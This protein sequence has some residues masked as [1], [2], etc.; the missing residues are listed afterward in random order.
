M[1][2]T[3]SERL[4]AAPPAVQIETAPSEGYLRAAVGSEPM[5]LVVDDDANWNSLITAA[6]KGL[7]FTSFAVTSGDEA[8]QASRTTRFD[9]G[10]LDLGLPGMS[11]LET[12]AALKRHDPSMTIVVASGDGSIELA[13][14][15][16]RLGAYDFL[17]KTSHPSDIVAALRR[18]GEERRVRGTA[19]LHEVSASLM[20]V[21]DHV[22]LLPRALEIAKRSLGADG[23]AIVRGRA[24]GAEP[25]RID[26]DQPLSDAVLKQCHSKVTEDRKSIRLSTLPRPQSEKPVAGAALVC[27][28]VGRG[29]A[30]AS[31][32]LVRNAGAPAFSAAELAD[33][34]VL[35]A[36]LAM[37]LENAELFER[38]QAAEQEARSSEARIRAVVDACPDAV[39]TIDRR[40]VIRDWNPAAETMYRYPAARAV[41]SDYRELIVPEAH[42]SGMADDVDRDGPSAQIAVLAAKNALCL[43]GS[44]EE[45]PAAVSVTPI[46]SHGEPLSCIFVRDL[47]AQTRL[48]VELRHAQK[49]ESVGRL[50]AGV[51]HEINTPIQFIGDS[52]E[53]ARS[54]FEALRK[55]VD[56]YRQHAKS[57]S[58][59]ALMAAEEEADL[60]YLLEQLP[61]AIGRTLDGVS[62]VARI[63]RAMKYFAHPG[64][65]EKS[66]ADLNRAVEETLIVASNE[67]KY[68]AAVELELGDIPQVTCHLEDVNQVLLNLVVN[69][70][71]AIESAN[72]HTGGRGVIRIRTRHEAPSVV[73]EISDT[74]CGIP[75]SIK[76]KVFDAFFTTKEPGRG[77]GQGLAL[78]RAVIVDKHGG[79]LTFESVEGAGTTFFIRLP[80]G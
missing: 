17:E 27:P 18:A 79:T 31:L 7:G 3:A 66:P 26:G 10:V 28:L 52:T 34:Q 49:L 20:A 35:A 1:R 45:F 29:G 60:T 19:T 50:A 58:H 5:V 48:E 46:L 38:M 75:E 21:R 77:T 56:V 64:Q 6:L 54:A 80:V 69:A 73:V 8:L 22:D 15:C 25:V 41:G 55:L 47:T 24:G 68:V 32:V 40:G 70:A 43:R 12:L 67:V 44:G 30:N 59:D 13:T 39:F 11:G 36:Q 71:H 76:R 72:R 53:F 61:V 33:G 78:A 16:M 62:R 23:A 42:R 65:G 2:G 51:A 63:V 14:Q 74:G 57:E 4:P 37:A 9:F